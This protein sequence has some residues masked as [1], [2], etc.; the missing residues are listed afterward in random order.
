[1]QIGINIQNSPSDKSSFSSSRL[2]LNILRM[3]QNLAK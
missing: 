2:C 1:M 3:K